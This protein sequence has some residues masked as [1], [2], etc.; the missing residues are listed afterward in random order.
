MV[1]LDIAF[2][3]LEGGNGPARVQGSALSLP[4]RDSAFDVVLAVEMIQHLPPRGLDR[5]LDEIRRVI[6]PAGTVAVIDRNLGA[7]DPN[8]PWLPAVVVKEID[9]ARGRWMYPRNSPVQERWQWP[10]R[11]GGKLSRQFDDVA[12]SYL[13]SPAEANRP[14]FRRMEQARRFVLWTARGRGPNKDLGQGGSA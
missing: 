9:Q 6:K 4:F 12:W 10:S 8:R 2:G 5:V 1:G 11:F 7:L 13:L 3:M 14:V